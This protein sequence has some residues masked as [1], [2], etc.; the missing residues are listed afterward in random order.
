MDVP[1]TSNPPGRFPVDFFVASAYFTPC[2]FWI[3]FR[4]TCSKA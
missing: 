2:Q 3:F 1:G 4:M